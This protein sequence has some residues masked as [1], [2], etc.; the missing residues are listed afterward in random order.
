MNEASEESHEAND[1]DQMS[2]GAIADIQNESEVETSST[3]TW[4]DY[5]DQL[6]T[7]EFA[8][9][10]FVRFIALFGQ[11]CLEVIFFRLYF[12]LSFW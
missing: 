10:I 12:S 1:L 9:I 8:A 3:A 7:G 4:A 5:L 11:T 2:Q 6:L